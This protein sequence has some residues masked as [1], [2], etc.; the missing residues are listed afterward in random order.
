[1]CIS[2]KAIC[3][4][5]AVLW[6]RLIFCHVSFIIMDSHKFL[7]EHEIYELVNHSDSDID[8][9]N[10]EYIVSYSDSKNDENSDIH[11]WEVRWHTKYSKGFKIAFTR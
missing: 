4:L 11:K 5:Y 2:S 10:S 9:A 1:M 6:V 7:T 3:V 8:V